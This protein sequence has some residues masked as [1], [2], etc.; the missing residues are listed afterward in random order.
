MDLR[1][2]RYFVVLSETLNFRR[3]AERLN[4]SQPPL[5]VAIRKLEAE[6]GADLFTRS[7]RGVS[8]TAAGEAALEPARAALNQAELV[9]QAVQEGADG[10]RGRIRIGFVNSAMYGLLPGLIPRFR[11]R[12]PH[13]AFVLEEGDSR[14][15]ARRIASRQLDVG[16]VRL[17]LLDQAEIEA[18]VLESDELLVAAPQ[19]HRLAGRQ[20]VR[21]AQLADDPFIAYPHDSLIH[22]L[23]LLACQRA[24]FAPQ[25]AQEVAQARTILSLV[26]S[27]L[28]VGL[29]PSRSAQVAPEGVALL[30][31]EEPLRVESGIILPRVGASPVARTMLSLALSQVS[32]GGAAAPPR[33]PALA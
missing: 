7:A 4:I 14:V 32:V 30:S 21:L 29:V 31:L 16:F 2:L 11:Q 19:G 17:P 1:Q 20:A 24:G 28:G 12:Y 8:L 25:V 26:Q 6:L 18:T 33:T 3:A 13:V 23:I 5:T 22:A 27:G 10:E 9:R 15:I